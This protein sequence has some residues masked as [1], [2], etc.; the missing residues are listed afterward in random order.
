MSWNP[1]LYFPS[2][3]KTTILL[4][5]N[6][7]LCLTCNLYSQPIFWMTLKF[8]FT[9]NR[10]FLSRKKRKKSFSIGRRYFITSGRAPCVCPWNAAAFVPLNQELS[11]KKAGAELTRSS[12]CVSNTSSSTLAS[13]ELT[14]CIPRPVSTI[15]KSSNAAV[16]DTANRKSGL[17]RSGLTTE[18][19]G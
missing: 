11:V 9:K 4:K 16:T 2:R 12:T 7:R 19:V 15:I 8:P 3:L 13:P 6:L 5:R 18:G 10:I 17:I 14:G 1:F